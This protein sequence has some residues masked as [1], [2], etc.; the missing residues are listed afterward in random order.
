LLY[1]FDGPAQQA[2]QKAWKEAIEQAVSLS[3]GSSQV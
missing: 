2:A 3:R 1:L